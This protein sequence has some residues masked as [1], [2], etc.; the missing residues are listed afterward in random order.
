MT[1]LDAVA[2]AIRERL[3]AGR[4]APLPGLGTLVRQHVSARVEERADGSR[5][6]LPPGETI[7]LAG[8]DVEH[9]SLAPAFGRLQALDRDAA[10]LAYADAMDQIEA[11]LAATGEVR[12]SGVGLLRRTSG[13]VVLGV[14]ADLLA[15]VNRTYEGL[16]PVGAAPA[17]PP[18]P[19][20]PDADAPPPEPPTPSASG[21][22]APDD[23]PDSLV[24]DDSPIRDLSPDPGSPFEPPASPDPQSEDSP[25]TPLSPA[26]VSFVDD[27]AL[28]ADLDD[29][30]AVPFGEGPGLSE[31]LPP[32]PP[33]RAPEPDDPAS[34]PMPADDWEDEETW[35]TP[36]ASRPSLGGE[37]H[38]EDAEVVSDDEDAPAPDQPTEP[39]PTEPEPGEPAPMGPSRE[40]AALLDEPAAPAAGEFTGLGPF[41]DNPPALPVEPVSDDAE[42]PFADDPEAP[43]PPPA[44]TAEAGSRFPWWLL[45][46][47]LLLLAGLAVAWLWPRLTADPAPR[48]SAERAPTLVPTAPTPADDASA[49]DDRSAAARPTPAAPGP[50]AAEPPDSPPP[51]RAPAA[52]ALLPPR[53]AGL[54]PADVQSLSS[55]EPV[56]ADADA[57]TWVVLSTPDRDRATTLHARYRAAGY[58]TAVLASNRGAR[59][60]YR[61]AVGQ[62]ASRQDA[63]RL[64]DRLPP[65]APADTWA[66]DLRTL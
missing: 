10:D 48:P 39:E 66:L 51:D 53:V 11:R 42:L 38:I 44:P 47:V 30:L 45:T 46:L 22:A 52:G 28:D 21:S 25:G 65:D 33:D 7:G 63:V 55:R 8:S 50:D 26:D 36:L 20:P 12:L 43:A 32:T 2:A 14:E 40:L 60:M 15:A 35:T 19:A 62:F 24:A 49:L 54:P 18:R 17:R 1:P 16:V 57:W 59:T 5:V 58:R 13:G 41:G 23:E 37:D 6:L 29:V 9:E 31:V 3:L 4:P 64:R 56:R 27:D 61:L 34:V